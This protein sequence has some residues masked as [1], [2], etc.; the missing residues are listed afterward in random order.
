M[1]KTII[2]NREKARQQIKENLEIEKI[3]QNLTDFKALEKAYSA[4]KEQF[5][6]EALWALAKQIKKHQ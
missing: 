2:G 4:N 3:F 6:P 5:V 1:K